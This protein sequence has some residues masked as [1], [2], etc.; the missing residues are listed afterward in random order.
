MR[1]KVGEVSDVVRTEYG[2]HLI[3]VTERN[4]GTPSD[5]AKIKEDLKQVIHRR[6]AARRAGAAAQA[7]E[8]RH[9]RAVT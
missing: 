1:M 4:P 5:Y 9:Q 8:D 3:K 2:L 7:L 6:D